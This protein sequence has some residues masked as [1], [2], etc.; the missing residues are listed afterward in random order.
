MAASVFTIELKIFWKCLSYVA[1]SKK[2]QQSLLCYNLGLERNNWKSCDNVKDFKVYEF[3]KTQKSNYREKVIPFYLQ[4]KK[5][6]QCE[7]RSI[8]WY[9]IIFQQRLHLSEFERIN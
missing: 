9:K 2:S 3:I 5:I 7:L 4:I 6:I 1:T 8:V